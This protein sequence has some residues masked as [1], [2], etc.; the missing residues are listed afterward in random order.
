VSG[1]GESPERS[2][3]NRPVNAAL[4]PVIGPE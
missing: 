4:A 2:A 3:P 1:Q